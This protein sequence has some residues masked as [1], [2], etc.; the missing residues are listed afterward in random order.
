MTRYEVDGC[1]VTFTKYGN[2]TALSV[3][4]DSNR[5]ILHTGNT[6]IEP[7]P[8]GAANA[9]KIYKALVGDLSDDNYE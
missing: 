1:T 8:E 3:T 2:K 7:T 5:A 6:N 9:A 4:S